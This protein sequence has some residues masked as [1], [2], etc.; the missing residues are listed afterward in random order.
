MRFSKNKIRE[1]LWNQIDH[2]EKK[3][4]F[5]PRNGSAQLAEDDPQERIIDYGAYAILKEQFDQMDLD[6]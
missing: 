3:H 4:R 1:I 6:E 2:L 5:D